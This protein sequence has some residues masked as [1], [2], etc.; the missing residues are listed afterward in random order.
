[1][2][3]HTPT[4]QHWQYMHIYR[5]REREGLESSRALRARLILHGEWYWAQPCHYSVHMFIPIERSSVRSSE[6][7]I[8]ETIDRWGLKPWVVYERE[9]KWTE[10]TLPIIV[11]SVRRKGCRRGRSKEEKM[12]WK[13]DEGKGQDHGLN[14]VRRIADAALATQQTELLPLEGQKVN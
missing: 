10:F 13:G 5:E 7:S 12:K 14:W 4:N 2:N 3:T 6:R 9:T 8:D 11:W 1:M